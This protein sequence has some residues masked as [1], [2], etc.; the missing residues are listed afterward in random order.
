M[1]KLAI[2]AAFA[3]VAS[4]HQSAACDWERDAAQAPQVVA[5]GCT[6]S[7]C[8]VEPAPVAQ[9]APTTQ[10]A[11]DECSGAKCARPEPTPMQVAGVDGT[12]D[13]H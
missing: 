4:A 8:A 12:G 5:D 10:E 7:N 6:G 11:A 2:L 9:P 1:K 3:L 13:R